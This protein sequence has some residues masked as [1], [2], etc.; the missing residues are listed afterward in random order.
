M[1]VRAPLL[2]ETLQLEEQAI[3]THDVPRLVVPWSSPWQEFKNSIR[4]AFAR[5][6]ARLAGEAPFG[7]VPLRIMIPS[8]LLE[9]F[10]IFAAI[11]VPAKI[12]ELQPYV[13]PAPRSHEVIY[14]SGDELPR[15]EDL[16]GAESGKT[17]R[18]GGA[19]AHHRTQTIKIARGGSLVPR[20]VDAPN[21]KLPAST[22]AVAN[23]LAI[24]PD[25]GP[26]PVEGSR[27]SRSTP[28]LATPLIAP[29]PEV[30]RDYTR[31]GVHL[32]ALIAPAP[33]ITRDP[34]T[35]APNLSATVI[36]PAPRVA[37]DHTLVAPALAPVVIP[38]ATNASS[39]LRQAPSLDTSLVAPAPNATGDARRSAPSLASNVIP[40][41]PNSG[42]REQSSSPLQMSNIAVVPPPVSAP[43]KSSTRNSQ[44]TM[45]APA[46]IAPPPST[47]ISQDMRRLPTGGAYDPS[48]AVVAPPQP[49]TGTLSRIIGRLFGSSD[50]VVPPPPSVN[51]SNSSDNPGGTSRA[52]LNPNVVA[53]PPSVNTAST[54]GNPRGVRNGMGAS[55]DG[56]VI[57]PP[58]SAGV[59]GGTG[60]H[61]LANS[62][63]PKLG[64][65]DVVPPPP[66]L[67]GPG[68]GTGYN[69]GGA[70]APGGKL[71]ANNVVP[72][73]P[74]VGEGTN[75]TGSGTGRRNI[76][77]GGPMDVGS[78]AAPPS[79]GGSG[80]NSG[81]VISSQ[82]GSK[83]GVPPTSAS[84]SLSLSPSGGDKPGLGGS[85]GGTGIGRGNGTGSGMTGEGTGAGKTG[86]ARGSDPNAHG[87]ISPTLGPG[88]A[89]NAPSG[90]PPVP[91]V[92]VEGGK[93]IITL[94]SF[95]S[96]S[97]SNTDPASPGHSPKIHGKELEVTVVASANS[98]GALE[99]YKNLL[100]G[101]T[102]TAYLDTSAGQVIVEFADE[103][104]AAHSF[105]DA[106]TAPGPVRVDL[107]AG[108]PHAR[109]TIKCTLDASGNLKNF[110]VLDPG[111]A[112]MT[113]KVL[114]ALR[115]WK[116]T[117]ATR[118]NQ[119]VEVTAILG[120]NIDTNDRF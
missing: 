44:L 100:H 87:G 36:P 61:T 82:P 101:Q 16:G 65:P 115:S 34:H 106:L 27:S 3:A 81:A 63:A 12:R 112:D 31:N 71:L 113:A 6:Q 33:S 114:A 104:T 56:K 88:G 25:P 55:L 110:R 47:N 66:A 62:S 79:N 72:P 95:G 98:G 107:P 2:I 118:N 10:L 59:S 45:P 38:P 96:D 119:P 20:V 103:T 60:T 50:D 116:L 41:A 80:S 39:N 30:I 28:S 26:P 15:T 74:S 35:A 51:P 85:G 42:S 22:G 90:S 54:G 105:G 83:V 117:P 32:D 91:G 19:E 53:P 111:P 97:S 78:P 13:V 68:G 84:G 99:P 7:L 9:A 69:G 37:S 52:S 92:S 17:G 29:P 40:P 108:L 120:F 70:G 77:L 1:G 64:V 11:I 73:P 8:Y 86:S 58:P 57:A 23:L 46:L 24:R 5:S 76:G 109:L 67:T 14:Y 89:G 94:P 21:V 4:P 75:P 43:E 102:Y 49:A 18:A 93:S 48:Q